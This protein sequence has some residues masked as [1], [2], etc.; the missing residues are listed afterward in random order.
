MYVGH[1]VA[2]SFRCFSISCHICFISG[3][4]NFFYSVFD[5]FAISI[6]VESF[7]LAF[8]LV[9]LIKSYSLFSVFAVSK[10]LDGYAFR[11]DAV[12]VI[13]IVPYLLNFY[14]YLFRCMSIG[15]SCDGGI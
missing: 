10:K 12:L 8:P 1:Y 14:F 15:K 2:Y 11:S 7:E 3:D 13:C 9:V 4:F 6:F 5:L